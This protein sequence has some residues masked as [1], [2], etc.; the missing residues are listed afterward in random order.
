MY[1]HLITY[2]IMLYGIISYDIILSLLYVTTCYYN[3]NHTNMSLQLYY[4]SIMSLYYHI[5]LYWEVLAAAGAPPHRGA[6][7]ARGVLR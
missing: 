1:T 5:I 4:H 7:G 3:Y 6:G 2:C